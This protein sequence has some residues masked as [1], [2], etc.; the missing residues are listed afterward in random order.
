MRV[1]FFVASALV[2]ASCQSGPIA[3]NL[4]AAPGMSA[5]QAVMAAADAAPRGVPGNFALVVR[6][7]EMVGPRLYLNSEDDYRDQRNLSIAIQPY[8]LPGLRDRLGKE[9]R[10]ALVG[11]DIRV[12]GVARR[13]RIA[14]FE[15]GKPTGLY[16]YQTHVVVDSAYQIS[17]VG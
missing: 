3:P 14:F 10:T 9:L 17:I 7:A 1:V 15:N 6:R 4:A 11:R 2:L 13:T 5:P 8:V 16:Y 12:R